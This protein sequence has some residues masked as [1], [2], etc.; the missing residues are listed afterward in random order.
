MDIGNE[1]TVVNTTQGGS[2]TGL[3]PWNEYQVIATKPW[4]MALD[5]TAA[6]LQFVPMTG[7]LP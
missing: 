2:P 7:A 6:N 5:A 1:V 3:T 4:N